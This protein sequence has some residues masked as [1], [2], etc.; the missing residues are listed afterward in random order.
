MIKWNDE[1][2]VYVSD[3]GKIWNHKKHELKLE[4][5]K[6]YKRLTR[7]LN[8]QSMHIFVHRLV[9][10]TFIGLIPSNLQIDH[11]NRVRDDNRLENLR[12]ATHSENLQNKNGYFYTTFGQKFKEHYGVT[13]KENKVLHRKEYL[14]FWRHGKCRWE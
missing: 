2:Q 1:Y 4:D 10:E 8:N 9:W 14:Y 6:G 13:H 12:L 3:E 11:I 5:I 7:H